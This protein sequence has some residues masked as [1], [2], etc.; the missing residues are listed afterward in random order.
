MTTEPAELIQPLDEEGCVDS[1]GQ[2]FSPLQT[3][4]AGT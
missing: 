2:G 3:L 1:A 4:Q